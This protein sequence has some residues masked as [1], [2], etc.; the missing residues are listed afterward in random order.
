MP[1]QAHVGR[2]QIATCSMF[3]RIMRR[4]LKAHLRRIDIKTVFRAY[5]QAGLNPLIASRRMSKPC[6]LI[7]KRD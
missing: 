3:G 4:V 2:E 7:R 5:R 1:K 6:Y